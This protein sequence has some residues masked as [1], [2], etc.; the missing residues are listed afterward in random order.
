[1]P[2][3]PPVPGQKRCPLTAGRALRWLLRCCSLHWLQWLLRG[4]LLSLLLL[5]AV[6]QVTE[7]LSQPLVTI[8]VPR[9]APFPRLTLC[10]A[11]S[12]RDWKL[13]RYERQRL[14][15]GNITVAEFYNLTTL[16][17]PSASGG[18]GHMAVVGADPKRTDLLSPEREDM[19]RG[20]RA[21]I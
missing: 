4:G 8:T 21:T 16:A 13:V 9:V 5:L 2:A 11:V 6:Q 10:P 15:D 19:A 7:Y 17:P 14:L 3:R 18:Y 1:M 12:L 20:M